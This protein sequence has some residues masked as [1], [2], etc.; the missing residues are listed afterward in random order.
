MTRTPKQILD[1]MAA[2]AR[3]T[4]IA[5]G[6]SWRDALFTRA[7]DG[8]QLS[9]PDEP[10][11]RLLLALTDEYELADGHLDTLPAR[12][13]GEWLESILGI[14]RLPVMPDR[15]VASATIDPKLAPA[16]VPAGTTLR[17]GK[18]AYGT[19][20]RYRTLDALTAHGATLVGVRATVPGGP[21]GGTPGLAFA[22]PG[23]PLAPPASPAEA[24]VGPPAPHVLR[25]SSPVLAFAQG[26]MSIR[27]TFD[28]AAGVDDLRV[29]GRWRHPKADGTLSTPIQGVGVTASDV[30][31]FTMNDGCIDPDG[32]DPWIECLIP[33]DHP[34]PESLHFNQVKVAVTQRLGVAADAAF[35]NEGAVN[36]TKEFDPFGPT[37]RQGDAF[38]VRCDEALSKPLTS[39]TVHLGVYASATGGLAATGGSTASGYLVTQKGHFGQAG[40]WNEYA[41]GATQVSTTAPGSRPA[42]KIQ[43]QN[44]IGDSWNKLVEQS[45]LATMV[46]GLGGTTGS[47]PFTVAGQEGRFVRAIIASGDL[48]WREYLDTVAYFATQAVKD[49]GNA[50]SMPTPP[51]PARYNNLSIDYTTLAHAATRVESWSGWRHLVM[52]SLGFRPFYRAVDDAGTPGMVAIG[53]DLPA[54]VTGSTVSLYVALDSAAPCGSTEDPTAHW[55]WW[56]GAAWRT[57]SVADGTHRMRE[58]G[59][60]RFVA[61]DGWAQGCEDVT[62]DAGRW[63]RFVTEEPSRIG[64]IHDVIPD[65]VIAE[66]MSQALDPGADPT[67]ATALPP[68]AIKGTLSP[69]AGVKK[70]TH[71]A[72]VRGRGPEPDEGFRRRASSLVRH[73]GRAITAW[74]YEQLVAEQFPEVAA[75]RCLPHVGSGGGRAP[76]WVGLVV[77]PDQRDK[78]QPKPSV[79]LAG[80]IG[81]ALRPVMAIGAEAAIL[82][83]IYIPVSVTAS[84]TLRRGVAALTGK[85]AVTQALDTLLHPTGMQPTRWGVSL[86]SSTLIA[87]LERVAVVDVVTSFAMRGPTGGAVEV[88]EVDTCRGLYCSSGDHLLTC[89]EQL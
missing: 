42:L 33:A 39:L 59:L 30:I 32:S 89:E 67:S 37:A 25:I 77:I 84:V 9:A 60:L 11:R 76:G 82:C 69:I 35:A 24:L 87:A 63:I 41:G 43:W 29:A 12:L 86:Y 58:A 80:R 44:K 49:P 56:D 71:L 2:T 1:T 5:E 46:K 88:I 38:Y 7:A 62:A 6:V 45:A 68:G 27:L 8:Y 75:V 50:P 72:S 36:I 22:A 10:D 55:E 34:V 23:F 4:P 13:H 64:V 3:L 74:D 20:R 57:L 79:S 18:D 40:W 16:V 66:Y 70:I 21:A 53:L 61:P 15:V 28:A 54:E 52:A 48:G 19:E 26:A 78:P 65:A 81:D 73:R 85:A 31:D 83:P 51:V 47:T 14:P 17:G